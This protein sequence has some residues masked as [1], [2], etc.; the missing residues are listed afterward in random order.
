MLISVNNGSVLWVYF[1]KILKALSVPL[2]LNYLALVSSLY[3]FP[4]GKGRE[5]L[6]DNRLLEE[7]YKTVDKKRDVKISKGE[8]YTKGKRDVFV[9]RRKQ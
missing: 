3:P 7:G 1:Y 5:R 6:P 4:F 2:E 9:Y 8:R